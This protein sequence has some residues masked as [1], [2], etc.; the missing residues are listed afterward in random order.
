[1]TDGDITV[2]KIYLLTERDFAYYSP[3]SI[4]A[5][6]EGLIFDNEVHLELRHKFLT[7]DGRE[8]LLDI[9]DWDVS[10]GSELMWALG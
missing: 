10:E 1:M 6:F 9:K 2:G 7:S 4:V 3:R 8:A 5:R